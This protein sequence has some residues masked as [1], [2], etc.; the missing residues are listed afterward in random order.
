MIWILFGVKDP[1]QGPDHC[2]VSKNEIPEKKGP[3]RTLFSGISFWG[4]RHN[5]GF[6]NNLE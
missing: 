2:Q 4:L 6:N 1:E 5:K 3:K